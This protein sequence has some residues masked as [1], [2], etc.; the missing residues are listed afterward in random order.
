MKPISKAILPLFIL[1]SSSILLLMLFGPVSGSV[2]DEPVDTVV[3]VVNDIP[4]QQSELLA[5]I[6]QYKK[7]THQ[8]SI[9]DNEK[10]ELL[11]GIIRRKLI[12][13]QSEIA[14]IRKTPIIRQRVKAFEDQMVLQYYLNEKIGSKLKITDHEMKKYYQAHINQFMAP[15]TV[16]ASHILLRSQEDARMV[17]GK[18]KNGGNFTELAKTY[19]ID[20]PM[21]LEGGSMGTIEKG[22]SLPQLEKVLFVLDEGEH[23]DIVKSR[24]G[25]HILQVDKIFR[26]RH[27]PYEEVREQIKGALTKEKDAQAYQDMVGVIEKDAQIEIY[28]NRL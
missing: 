25:Y 9:D 19:S 2:A 17:L 24:Y 15:P 1:S 27:R 26:N 5:L 11:N 12:L 28:K 23:S 6:E 8:L 7:K 13:S 4:I 18:L 3:A 16:E 22:K 21:A 20:L 10:L 14:E